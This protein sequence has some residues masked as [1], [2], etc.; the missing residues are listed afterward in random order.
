MEPSLSLSCA[1]CVAGKT[2]EKYIWPRLS[3]LQC[4]YMMDDALPLP[5][6]LP[7]PPLPR[8]HPYRT[9]RLAHAV[10]IVALLALK[11]LE[12]RPKPTPPSF[13]AD[14]PLSLKEPDGLVPSP[15]AMAV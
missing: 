6:P 9:E 1:E 11:D 14:G 2:F 12:K 8:M 4:T 13:R 10:F 3:I 15:A 5:L 7:F